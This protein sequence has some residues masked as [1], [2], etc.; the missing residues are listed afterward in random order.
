MDFSKDMVDEF[1]IKSTYDGWCV[2]ILGGRFT[3]S[4]GALVDYEYY[5]G[6]SPRQI[7]STVRY[8]LEKHNID[9]E[10]SLR[11]SHFKNHPKFKEGYV[12]VEIIAKGDLVTDCFHVA[13]KR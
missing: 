13:A 11:F 12:V 5:Y 3:T 6:L 1:D 4:S 7:F 2:E 9:N 10:V 8:S